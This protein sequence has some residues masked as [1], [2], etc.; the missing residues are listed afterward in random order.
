MTCKHGI[1]QPT[2]QDIERLEEF[3]RM[4]G[5]GQYDKRGLPRDRARY[6]LWDKAHP[7][8]TCHLES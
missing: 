1:K 2:P 8:R 7:C 6:L 5:L 4:L 3:E